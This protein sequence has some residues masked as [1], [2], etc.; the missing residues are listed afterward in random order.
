MYFHFSTVVWGDWHTGVYLDANLPSLLAPENLPAFAKQH[1]VTYRILTAARD[2]PRIQ[3]S[4]AFQ[5]A[6]S[7]VPFELIAC[8]VE[9]TDNPIAVHHQ[10]WRRSIAEAREAGA[11]I[12]FVPP[13]VIWANGS[14]GH[15]ANLIEQGKR[16]VF[17]TYMRVVSETCVPAAR[18]RHLSKDGTTIDA[19]PRELVRLCFEHIHPLTLTYLRDSPNFPIHPE[20]ILWPVAGE[21]YLMRVLV[22]EMFA[23][24]PNLI[25]L[26]RQALPANVPD[27]DLIHYINDS[28]DL[29]SLS[30]APLTKD[31]DWYMKPQSLDPIKIA[32]WWLTYDSPANDVVAKH[33]FYVHSVPKTPEKWRAAEAESDILMRKISGTREMLRVIGGFQNQDTLYARQVLSL[34]LAE[35][36]L[37]ELLKCDQ[38][39]T[40]LIPNDQATI[41]WL[42]SI[43]SNLFEFSKSQEFCRLI[44]DHVLVGRIPSKSEGVSS[45][46]TLG[47]GVRQVSWKDGA[48]FVDGMAI[49]GPGYSLVSD[50][51]LNANGW[52]FLVDTV[53]P[54]CSSAEEVEHNQ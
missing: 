1:D 53:L 21:G 8:P 50:P 11:M 10:L 45:L 40:V 7:I 44:L 33:Y 26:N 13:D 28:D 41:R 17:M 37:P 27:L 14:I 52:A 49:N 18:R 12:L 38:A 39:F 24:D 34:A 29:F 31:A 51:G 32:D 16:A 4:A 35:T 22:R 6:Q 20:F 3:S 5:R 36:K 54:S 42:Q 30:L 43:G 25:T 46:K 48:P 2:I 47:G 23:Y 9:N 19:S 15:V